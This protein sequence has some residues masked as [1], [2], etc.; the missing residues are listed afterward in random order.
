MADSVTFDNPE[1]NWP[2][3][4]QSR[5]YDTFKRIIERLVARTGGPGTDSISGQ[6]DSISLLT[7]KVANLELQTA[8]LTPHPVRKKSRD[9]Y[10]QAG[11]L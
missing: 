1:L 4:W 6:A 10:L 3:E 2:P 8:T 11:L 9:K 5:E 7:L